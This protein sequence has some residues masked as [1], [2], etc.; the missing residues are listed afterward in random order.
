MTKDK[1]IEKIKDILRTDYKIVTR[2]YTTSRHNFGRDS[3]KEIPIQS[4]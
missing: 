2:F 3:K 4:S 1:L